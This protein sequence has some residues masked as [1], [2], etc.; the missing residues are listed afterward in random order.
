MTFGIINFILFITTIILVWKKWK[1]KK[2]LNNQMQLIT[3]T[4]NP[5]LN[6]N[7]IRNL[8]FNPNIGN[9]GRNI[10]IVGTWGTILFVTLGFGF[11]M[12]NL[13]YLTGWNIGTFTEKMNSLVPIVFLS[14]IWPGI[15]YF[16]NPKSITIS[17]D[18]IS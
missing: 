1:G 7:S 4:S 8:Q 17:K 3:A 13:L 18:T 5:N 11:M 16:N 12:V 15:F 6:Q 2:V 14:F 9:D 10:N